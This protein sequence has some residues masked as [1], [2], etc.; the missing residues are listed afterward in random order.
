MKI[1]LVISVILVIFLAVRIGRWYFTSTVERPQAFDTVQYDWFEVRTLPSQIVAM[2]TVQ[3]S[4]ES[5]ASWKW[6]QAL[7]WF[8]F[9]NNTSQDTIAMTAPVT[10]QQTSQKIA[11]T[12]PVTAQEG[13]DWTYDVSFIMPSKWTMDTLPVPNNQA[14]KISKQDSYTIAVRKFGGYATTSEV[15]NQ[16]QLFTEA[17]AKESIKTSWT[18]TLAQYN[19]PRTPPRM[20]TNELWSTVSED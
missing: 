6:F 15:S 19:D 9:G 4:D 7:A 14:I 13:S 2:V 16:K 12:A 20:R 17:L 1:L 3:A 5:N 8:I 11:M 18:L 10:A